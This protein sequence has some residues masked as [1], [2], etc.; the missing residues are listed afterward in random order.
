DR[1]AVLEV[2]KNAERVDDEL[3]RG[4]AAQVGNETDAARVML[5]P[6]VE[7]PARRTKLI[8]P[9][10]AVSLSPSKGHRLTAFSA[11]GP[12]LHRHSAGAGDHPRS[13]PGH[14]RAPPPWLRADV[15]PRETARG[16]ASPR[17]HGAHAAPSGRS[18]GRCSD[19]ARP[20]PT[21]ASPP[22]APWH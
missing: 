17:G 13:R 2:F 10:S 8:R 6:G 12:A 4:T 7:Q 5:A 1:S 21:G 14:P 22:A 3:V 15:R 18:R 11:D 19:A 9:R 16:P 20:P